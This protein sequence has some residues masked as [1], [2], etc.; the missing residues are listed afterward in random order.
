MERSMWLLLLTSIVTS[1]DLVGKTAS[2]P[3]ETRIEVAMTVPQYPEKIIWI[4][5]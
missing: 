5:E 3:K 2:S 4:V 1:S